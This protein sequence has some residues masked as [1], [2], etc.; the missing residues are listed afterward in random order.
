M[1]DSQPGLVKHLQQQIE[2]NSKALHDLQEVTRKLEQMNGKLQESEGLKSHFLSNIR[3]E[4][5]NP[6]SAIMGLSN[7]LF[8]GASPA[9]LPIVAR[10]IYEEAFNLDFQLQN[11]FAAAEL[12]AGEIDPEWAQVDVIGVVTA[13]LDLLDHA[14]AR[15][16]LDLTIQMPESLI[17][18]SDARKL[19]LIVIN[20]LANA[21]EYSPQESRVEVKAE[22]VSGQLHIL[23]QDHG[24]G[25][26]LLDQ[27]AIFDRFRQ[28]Q[29][30]TTKD[31][32]G[33]GLGLS[34]CRSL[35]E[36][37]GG[38]IE[39]QSAPG[40]GTLFRLV[41]PAIEVTSDIFATE[42]NLFLFGETERF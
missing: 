8:A 25:I 37:L 35:A 11:I 15:K 5:N 31:H 22:L 7:R 33:H 12:E 9:N 10:M 3:N 21:V 17:F 6:L 34:I 32:R 39:L 30:G 42:G 13:I 16:Q 1:P 40:D 38:T 27:S 4:I 29:S 26:P 20:L 18:I 36:L 23:V 14:I 41:L 28:L 2:L 19:H 24:A